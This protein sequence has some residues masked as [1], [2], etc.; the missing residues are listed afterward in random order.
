MTNK[1]GLSLFWSEEDQAFI[2]ISPE[3]PGL[4][5][6]GETME[7]ALAEGKV[8]LAL[9]IEEYKESGRELPLPQQ[10][11]VYSGQF[12]VRL[13][14]TL[15]RQAS[16]LA[17]REGV[18]LNQFVVVA[19]AARVGAEDMA[20]NICDRVADKLRDQTILAATNQINHVIELEKIVAKA[21]TS[22][23]IDSHLTTAFITSH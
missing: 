18:S 23:K 15:H 17:E 14:K 3:F 16:E 8:A 20:E 6:F 13:P 19:V 7:E 4:S 5:A 1:Y 11:S 21:A 22:N 10:Q 2:T 12:R 9:M